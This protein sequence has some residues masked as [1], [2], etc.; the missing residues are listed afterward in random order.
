MRYD[1][2]IIGAGHNGLTCAEANL[3][4][5]CHIYFDLDDTRSNKVE[6]PKFAVADNPGPAARTKVG[7]RKHDL[8][9][10]VGNNMRPIGVTYA[11]ASIEELAAAGAVEIANALVD[12]N[13][14]TRAAEIAEP[15][16]TTIF[17]GDFNVAAG[18]R[19][20]EFMTNGTGYSD[21]YALANADSPLG[22][23]INGA[24]DA[25]ES[26]DGG[27]R[28]DY[29]LMNDDSPLTVKE[30]QVIFADDRYGVVSDH[31]GIYARFNRRSDISS[32]L[33]PGAL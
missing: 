19:M 16:G 14:L 7:D 3:K 28:I 4:R 6:L 31:P 15:R 22:A 13:L 18:T 2:I 1:V 8:I 10:A 11:Y 20:Q 5:R 32:S 29:M 21:Q 33:R 23:T 25:W 26:A 9:G 24:I 27:Q 30:A 17:C 12:R